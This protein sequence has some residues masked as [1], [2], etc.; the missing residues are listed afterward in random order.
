MKKEFLAII[1]ARKNSKGIKNKNLLK[2]G[3]KELFAWPISAAKKSKFIERIIVST[4]SIKI[5]KL[6]KKYGADV[7]FLRPKKYAKDN[8]TSYSAIKHCLN[9]LKKKKLIYKNFILLEPTS[10]LT[11]TQDINTAIKK[12]LINKN[13]KALIGVSRTTTSHPLFL[14]KISKKGFLTPAIGKKFIT[15]RRQKLN[16]VY[17]FDG[18]IYISDINYYLKKQTFNHNKTIP[19][20]FPKYKSFELD[21]MID[22]KII[23]NF[24]NYEKN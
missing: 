5:S 14:C 2:L 19:M 21:D 22:F 10:P 16:D 8:S 12:F 23:D 4:D 6:A 20:I 17:F 9:F 11:S 13:A 1:L 3:K 18:S 7:P 15:T 24:K